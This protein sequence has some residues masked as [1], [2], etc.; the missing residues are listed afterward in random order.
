MVKR[1]K[2]SG[3]SGFYV[4]VSREGGIGRGDRIE[5]TDRDE[6]AMTVDQVAALYVG[7]SDDRD[8]LKRAVALPATAKRLLLPLIDASAIKAT[9]N[10]I[11]PAI[12]VLD[13]QSAE[14]GTRVVRGQIFL[15]IVCRRL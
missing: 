10:V 14:V 3:R 8:L 2:Q 4:A 15:Q 7:D 9:L 12:A 5:L 11:A 13:S 1:F 6:S